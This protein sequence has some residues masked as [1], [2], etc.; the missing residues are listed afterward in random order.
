MKKQKDISKCI[1]RAFLVKVQLQYSLMEPLTLRGLNLKISDIRDFHDIMAV[2][3]EY[4]Y[5]GSPKDALAE[6]NK[7]KPTVREIFPKA[8]VKLFQTEK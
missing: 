3:G 4:I 8:V 5:G 7:L 2:C 1:V 6:Y